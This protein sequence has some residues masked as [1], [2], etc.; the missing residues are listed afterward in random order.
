VALV[1]KLNR[2]LGLPSAPVTLILLMGCLVC[3]DPAF[4]NG[5]EFF[6]GDPFADDKPLDTQVIFAGSVKDLDGQ[7]I[8]DATIT[9]A[10]TVDTPRGERPITYNAYTNNIGRYRALDV[11]TVIMVMEQV[12]VMVDP[13]QVELSVAKPGFEVVRRL[14]RSR[15][16]QTSGVFE[17][18]FTMRTTAGSN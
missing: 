14:D 7:P 2:A 1:S 13:R 18:D 10:I 12:A 15:R 5:D 4:S 3:P 6:Q 8:E 16:S 17:I 11:A 9:V